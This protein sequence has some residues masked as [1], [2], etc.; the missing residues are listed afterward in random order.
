MDELLKQ[1]PCALAD[2]KNA[3]FRFMDRFIR[4]VKRY[5]EEYRAVMTA[6]AEDLEKR[7]SESQAALQ[8][9]SETHRKNEKELQDTWKS[10]QE[11]HNRKLRELRSQ[12]EKE[13]SRI[14]REAEDFEKDEKKAED[15]AWQ[16]ERGA[17]EAYEKFGRQIHEL[18]REVDLILGETIAGENKRKRILAGHKA[19]KQV[20][21]VEEAQKL[22]SE[23]TVEKA[24]ELRSEIQRIS[25]SLPRV[26][27]FHSKRTKLV[28]EF[29]D[30][31]AKVST[32]AGMLRQQMSKNHEIRQRNADSRCRAK[33]ESCR[34]EKE[35]LTLKRDKEIEKE[36][37]RMKQQ[38]RL[39]QDKSAQMKAGHAQAY[40][41]QRQH[42]EMQLTQ[43]KA[44]WERKRNDCNAGFK[45]RMAEEYPPKRVSAW[46]WQF[47]KHPRRV[48]DYGKIPG[49]E[50]NAEK[51][52][53]IGTAAVP[54]ADWYEGPTAGT[55]QTVLRNYAWLFG[56]NKQTAE[57]SMREKKF[58]LPYAISL[59]IGESLLLSHD[60]QSAGRA[61]TM[62]NA[63]GM[64]LLRSAPA[65][66]LRFQ[67]FDANGIG[68]FGRLLS[69]DP[70][71]KNNPGEPAV[72]SLAIGEGGRI[73]SDDISEQ[74]EETKILMDDLAA[75]LSRYASLRE[76][77]Q[78]NPL[79]KQI[80]RAVLM[81]NFPAG[82]KETDIRRLNAMAVHCSKWGFSMVLAQPDK[83]RDAI[84]PE[85][86]RFLEELYL[87]VTQIR[88]QSGS[89]D[90]RVINPCTETERHAGISLYGLP[91][92]QVCDQIAAEIRKESVAASRRKIDFAQAKGICPEPAQKYTQRADDAI[93]VPVGYLDGGQP[94]KLQFDDTHVHA[95]IMGNTG[96]GKTNLL[97]VLITNLMLRYKPSEVMIYLIDFKYGLDFRIYTQYNL[98]N[99]RSIG[100]TNEPEFALAVLE[101]IEQEQDKRSRQMGSHYL[102]ISDYNAD[103]PERKM[104]RILLIVDELYELVKQA[105][106]AIQ[107]KII[108]K[109]DSLAHQARSFGIH[110]VIS[111]QDL[112][113]IDKFETIKNQCMTRLA[114][115]C[116]D[117]QVEN[118]I[119]QEG[120]ARM[121]TID[122]TD[123]GACVFS[124]SG[125]KD[126]QIEHTA[127]LTAAQRDQFVTEIHNHYTAAK[128][129]TRAK[130]LTT[131]VGENRRHTIQIFVERG[132]LPKP[133]AH[134]LYVG[135]PVSLERELHFHP[136]TNV[137]L[138]GGNA[139][140]DSVKA[141]NSFLFFA[142]L[143][144]TLE[145]LELEK[146]KTGRMELL[147]TNFQ[148]HPMR[149]AE[150]EENDRCGQLAAKFP[151]LYKY[152]TGGKFPDTLQYLLDELDER[153]DGRRTSNTELWW[154]LA[155]P[156]QFDW[157]TAAGRNIAIDLQELLKNGPNYNIHVILWTSDVK[158][159]QSLQLTNNLF[160]ERV[161]L[162]MTSEEAKLVCGQ[163]LK[164][165][166]E[167]YRAVLIGR[168]AVR[169]RV[170]DLPDG[171]WMQALFD[172][173]GARRGQP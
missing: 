125:G 81:M 79:S 51:N 7:E 109:I 3:M 89:D 27:L 138:A 61:Q 50:K 108:D 134:K 85:W 83:E 145:K 171:S 120:V 102:K 46:M 42:F 37:A 9:L 14:S 57:K 82:L 126:P 28:C 43:A 44:N 131:R 60:S 55:I 148:D 41:R 158:K 19:V 115:H 170:Y 71:N 66:M 68:A 75:Q 160:G 107:K 136:K 72:K 91:N 154:F 162:E 45:Q 146:Q 150:D 113:K 122:S 149:S 135:D 6:E 73:H 172:R 5:R 74:I 106:D 121:H 164:P 117:S 132:T 2:E 110:M 86:Q 159:A 169:F 133:D 18:Y 11:D 103:N 94:F 80:Y 21:N 153:R 48:E 93:I 139:G 67:L 167:G 99:F 105:P 127:L 40:E 116:E 95:I 166:P 96:S 88:I 143:S 101:H 4:T 100:V 49:I 47:W 25:E 90:L 142:L 87:H 165:M 16:E 8:R 39:Y 54:I 114:L 58:C 152:N 22:L 161:C 70:A 92:E 29:A 32:A 15:T 137:W 111:G 163:D 23:K 59:E 144:L 52:V 12:T 64:R 119:S 24:E 76:F 35:K 36:N 31:D 112:D 155:A 20:K 13:I 78:K 1:K 147:C 38:E 53:L 97:H 130:V 33:R 141:G 104:N 128:R 17:V 65:C 84:K 124:V 173:F 129:Y 26:V 157:M 98:P 123:Q 118:L 34:K 56:A 77:N 62:M 30:L 168:S 151:A 63:I 156:E 69:L 140:A 10:Q